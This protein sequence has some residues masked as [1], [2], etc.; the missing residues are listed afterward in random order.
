MHG[1][2]AVRLDDG[3]RPSKLTESS[4]VVANAHG[5]TVTVADVVGSRLTSLSDVE[6]SVVLLRRSVSTSGNQHSAEGQAY[7]DSP[8]PAARRPRRSALGRQKQAILRADRQGRGDAQCTWR[9]G[10][11]LKDLRGVDALDRNRAHW[12][13]KLAV[14]GAE[15][16]AFK[17]DRV[18]SIVDTPAQAVKPN[19]VNHH[20]VPDLFLLLRLYCRRPSIDWRGHASRTLPAYVRGH[21]ESL[22]CA[23]CA[24]LLFLPYNA[25]TVTDMEALT[26]EC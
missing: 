18:P 15:P 12:D 25:D 13:C 3:E 11:T 21:G 23:V 6:I 10:R 9:E 1:D 22:P 7:A 17:K 14:G 19:C 5:S 24:T 16:I 4:G 20:W 8:I 2:G 26:T